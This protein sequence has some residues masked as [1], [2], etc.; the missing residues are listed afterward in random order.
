[1]WF[2]LTRTTPGLCVVMRFICALYEVVPLPLTSLGI[3][4]QDFFFFLTT[5]DFCWLLF[6]GV[7]QH[8]DVSG[9]RLA[10]F[11]KP[12]ILG[13]LFYPITVELF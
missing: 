4:E 7:I 6:T 5:L 9:H 8:F 3:L 13:W 1:M 2:M 11:T 12:D 10:G